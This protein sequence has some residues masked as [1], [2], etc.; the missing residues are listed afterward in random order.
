[1]LVLPPLNLLPP[2]PDDYV[3]ATFDGFTQLTRPARNFSS[4]LKAAVLAANRYPDAVFR[5]F[6]HVALNVSV[7]LP[8]LPSLPRAVD[9][10]HR[11]MG[12]AARR[13]TTPP[14]PPRPRMMKPGDVRRRPFFLLLLLRCRPCLP[15]P[16]WPATCPLG[17]RLCRCC[18]RCRR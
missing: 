9:L 10:T 7:R 17:P 3:Q 15:P 8:H 11:I 6:L 18:R 13:L 5:D 4:R 1:M 12:Y 16:A 14:W 2:T